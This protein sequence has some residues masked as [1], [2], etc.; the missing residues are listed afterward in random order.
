MKMKIISWN[1]NGVNACLKKGLLDFMKSEDADVYCFQEMKATKEK[2][3]KEIEGYEEFHAHAKKKGYSGVSVYSKHSPERVFYGLGEERFDDEG[4]VVGL[5][6]EDFILVNVYFPHSSRDLKRIDFKLD[7][8][9]K[10]LEFCKNL[11]KIKPVV[12]ASDFNVAHK[13]IDLR[14]P[15]QNMKNAG[16]TIEEREWFDE[17]LGEGFVDSFREFTENGEN[18]TWWSYRNN[19]RERNIG[20]RIDYFVISEVLKEKLIESSILKDVLGS[21]HCPIR[22]QIS[23]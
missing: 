15:K 5:E 6:F 4:R 16:F 23:F 13:E 1:V 19:A 11:E 22:L 21:D 2:L 18:Y 9:K 8:N 12:I 17:F 14:N 10:F 3:P 7:F 20:W